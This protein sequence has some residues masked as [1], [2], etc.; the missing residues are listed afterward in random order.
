MAAAAGQQPSGPLQQGR[1][2]QGQYVYW[3]NQAHPSD[4]NPHGLKGLAD[5]ETRAAS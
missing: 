4:V 1:G 3:V 5:F 2:V